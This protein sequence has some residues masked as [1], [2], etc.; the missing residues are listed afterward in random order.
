MLFRKLFERLGGRLDLG[1]FPGIFVFLVEI[2]LPR[3]NLAELGIVDFGI[4]KGGFY[5]FCLVV[6]PVIIGLDTDESGLGKMTGSQG[7][8]R[9]GKGGKYRGGGSSSSD[10]SATRAMAGVMVYRFLRVL[11]RIMAHELGSPNWKYRLNRS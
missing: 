10:P 7:A 5:G 6:I 8:G 11:C 4:E 1:H 3:F 9:G 2:R